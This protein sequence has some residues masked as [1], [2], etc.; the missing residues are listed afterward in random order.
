[1]NGCGVI[2]IAKIPDECNNTFEVQTKVFMNFIG[3]MRWKPPASAGGGK[4]IA[5]L[6]G[7]IN[8]FITGHFLRPTG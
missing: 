7:R 6:R 1:V 2:I 4:R 5:S 3:I 8:K